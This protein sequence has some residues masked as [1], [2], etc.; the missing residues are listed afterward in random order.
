[1]EK[2]VAVEDYFELLAVATVFPNFV[3]SAPAVLI[4]EAV[5]FPSPVFL[6]PQFFV[7]ALSL[8]LYTASNLQPP[9]CEN[10]ALPRSSRK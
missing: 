10:A 7:T 1:M 9:L 4:Q 6:C 3:L 5:L 2:E 8:P